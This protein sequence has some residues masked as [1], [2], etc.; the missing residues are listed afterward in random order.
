MKNR[1]RYVLL[2]SLL[3]IMTSI[4]LFC[5]E[6]NRLSQ[7]G[8]GCALLVRTMGQMFYVYENIIIK[9]AKECNFNLWYGDNSV[10]DLWGVLDNKFYAC[11]WACCFW[12]DSVS[13][14]QYLDGI[15]SLIIKNAW[16][17]I[18][19]ILLWGHYF[20]EYVIRNSLQTWINNKFG[21]IWKS[22]L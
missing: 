7:H 19:W 10:I 17:A 9:A 22:K 15:L 6:V 8:F 12:F 21:L 4:Y 13:I 14:N 1:I 16:T 11:F 18:N 2:L 3:G 5:L 20:S